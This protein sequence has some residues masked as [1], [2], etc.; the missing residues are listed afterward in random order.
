MFKSRT[1]GSVVFKCTVRLL[2]ELDVLECEFQVCHRNL[3]AAN[4]TKKEEGK[5]I[6]HWM[7]KRFNEWNPSLTCDPIID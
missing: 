7:T 2:E 3:K 4:P 6:Q 1:E 5:Q